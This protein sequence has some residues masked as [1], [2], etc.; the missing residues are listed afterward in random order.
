MMTD[1]SKLTSNELYDKYNDL[2]SATAINAKNKYWWAISKEAAIQIGWMAFIRAKEDFRTAEDL[3]E[4]SNFNAYVGMRIYGAVVDEVR[5][6]QIRKTMVNGKRVIIPKRL[7]SFEDMETHEMESILRYDDPEDYI[8]FDEIIA[9]L[10][11]KKFEFILRGIYQYELTMSHLAD[12]LGVSESRI[13]QLHKNA[14][15]KLR[16]KHSKIDYAI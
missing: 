16:R 2:V 5:R 3:G 11:D 12:S 15:S 6:R 10:D 1:I 8:S 7:I 4:K 14:L 13:S 9:L